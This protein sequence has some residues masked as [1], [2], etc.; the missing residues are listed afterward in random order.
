MTL[1]EEAKAIREQIDSLNATVSDEVAAKSPLAFKEWNPNGIQYEKDERLQYEGLLYKVI[2]AHTSQES[3]NPKDAP[4]LFTVIDVEHAGTI[5]DPIPWH[6]N[7]I[8][9]KDKYYTEDGILYICTRDSEI[10]LQYKASEL[11][12]HYFELVT[13]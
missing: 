12:G 3:W 11:I 1:I 6:V 10:A 8:S 7:M 9:Y 5:D 2:T 4:S 13:Q